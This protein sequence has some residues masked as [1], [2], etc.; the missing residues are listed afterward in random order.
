MVFI[1]ALQKCLSI[2]N[3]YDFN[4]FIELQHLLRPIDEIIKNNN[5]NLNIIVSVTIPNIEKQKKLVEEFNN[6][7]NLQREK[8]NSLFLTNYRESKDISRKRI[9]FDLVYNI[10]EYILENI[11]WNNIYFILYNIKYGF[12]FHFKKLYWT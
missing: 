1:V 12:F 11:I 6:F 7:L 10:V 9:S 2:W 3:N 5:D 8:Y 4:I